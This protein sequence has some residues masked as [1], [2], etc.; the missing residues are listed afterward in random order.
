M[1]S[2]YESK[3]QSAQTVEQPSELMLNTLCHESWVLLKKLIVGRSRQET[4][5]LTAEQNLDWTQQPCRLAL[6]SALSI[7]RFNESFL[8]IENLQADRLSDGCLTD[9]KSLSG[10]V[11]ALEL[12]DLDRQEEFWLTFL[13]KI[14]QLVLETC[15]VVELLTL[16]SQHADKSF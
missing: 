15:F 4:R 12:V 5:K 10:K 8:L 14:V 9:A 1:D 11:S 7:D 6:S 13:G 3:N 16:V 2:V